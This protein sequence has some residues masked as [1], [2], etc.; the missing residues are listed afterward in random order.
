M[1]AGPLIGQVHEHDFVQQ[2]LVDLAA[3]FRG[4][5]FHVPTAWPWRL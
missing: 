4:I 3:Q 5:D 1:R 2:L